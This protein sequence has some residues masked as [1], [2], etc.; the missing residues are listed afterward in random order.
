MTKIKLLTRTFIAFVTAF[1]ILCGMG[2]GAIDARAAVSS[3][4]S[5]Y[6]Q[7]DG[8]YAQIVTDIYKQGY[9]SAKTLAGSA[10]WD[11]AHTG[12][13]PGTY[14]YAFDHPAI[15]DSDACLSVDKATRTLNKAAGIVQSVKGTTKFEKALALH[16]KLMAVTKYDSRGVNGEQTAYAALIGGKAACNGYAMAYKLLCDVSDIPCYVVVGTGANNGGSENHAW[17]V[18]QLDDGAWYEVD[19]TWDDQLGNHEFFGLT[20]AQ[21]KNIL[22]QAESKLLM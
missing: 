2:F 8:N 14:V 22:L 21:M 19:V 11:N 20:T 12:Y 13:K 7:S 16:D 17:N 1:T 15:F 5:E 3:V 6:I 18:I 10:L 9:E 4:H